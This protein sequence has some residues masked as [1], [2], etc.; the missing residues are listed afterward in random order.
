MPARCES[1]SKHVS[2]RR[3]FRLTARSRASK[4]ARARRDQSRQRRQV[5]DARDILPGASWGSIILPSVLSPELSRRDGKP[6]G[7]GRSENAGL[8]RPVPDGCRHARPRGAASPPLPPG[9]SGAFPPF[10][11]LG[12]RGRRGGR[13]R[14]R[15]SHCPAAAPGAAA[16]ARASFVAVTGPRSRRSAPPAANGARSLLRRPTHRPGLQPRGAPRRPRRPPPGSRPGPQP[17]RPG[18]PPPARTRAR[19]AT[20]RGALA[21]CSLARSRALR[22]DS[23][24][25]VGEAPP[26]EAE[27]LRPKT[28]SP[29]VGET[30]GI[31]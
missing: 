25:P 30:K 6:E 26:S 7:G 3:G 29:N 17:R 9:G 28:S 20:Y 23:R 2:E 16:A 1:Y 18:R 15:C 24:F 22:S 13:G 21:A 12:R 19:A 27:A 11:G 5:E 8:Q 4:R 31:C 14:R 10:P